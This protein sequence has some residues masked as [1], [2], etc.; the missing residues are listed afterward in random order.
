MLAQLAAQSQID[1]HFCLLRA[2]IKRGFQA[3]LRA[4]STS[5]GESIQPQGIHSSQF[6][7]L[8]FMS[9]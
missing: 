5:Y 7:T 3:N 2:I 8:V 4:Q 9:S 6:E 1:L